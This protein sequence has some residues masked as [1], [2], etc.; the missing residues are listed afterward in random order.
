M[1]KLA[2]LAGVSQPYISQIE[3]G[4]RGI[5]SPEILKKLHKHLGVKYAELMDYA[6]YL[7]REEVIELSEREDEEEKIRREEFVK[8]H[9]KIV[10]LSSESAD[11]YRIINQP[12]ANYRGTKLT[13][14]DKISLIDYLNFLL[15][16]RQ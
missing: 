2:K 10:D 1:G 11:L 5:P 8:Q 3:G 6:G 12:S 13:D 15:R 4:Q 14:A 9:R 16:D 7:S